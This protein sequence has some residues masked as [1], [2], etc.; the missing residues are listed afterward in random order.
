MRKQ[1]RNTQDFFEIGAKV[2]FKR[3]IDK[4]W[5]GPGHAIGQ[6]GATV[7]ITQGGLLY[8]VHCSRTQLITDFEHPPTFDTINLPANND[9]LKTGRTLQKTNPNTIN[10]DSDDEMYDEQTCESNEIIDEN[11]NATARNT[12]VIE[13]NK[14][15]S[16]IDNTHDKTTKNIK[17]GRTVDFSI[18]DNDVRAKIMSRAG[19][20]TGKFKNCFNARHQHP[21]DMYLSEGHVD[22]DKVK[23]CSIS[24]E[25]NDTDEV[26]MIDESCFDNAKLEELHNWK[27]NN[28]YEEIPKTNQKLL[29]CRWVCTMKQTDQNQVPKARLVVKGFEEQ[30]N[31]ILKDSPT[32]SKKGLRL[33]LSI[34]A[35]NKWKI[36]AA[37]I[38]TA[39]L[40]G[41]EI[42]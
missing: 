29:H 13:K 20:A 27:S 36:N 7:Y 6:D 18:D 19:K 42:D 28:V 40:Q 33:I 32:C 23:S 41:E 12:N 25:H 24:H 5:H 8:K 30:T 4:I 34:I 11:I 14:E 17:L 10:C 1:T 9:N 39:F 38:K 2:Y 35:H 37:D 15:L 26:Y 31:E 21:S 16:N 3:N 22:F